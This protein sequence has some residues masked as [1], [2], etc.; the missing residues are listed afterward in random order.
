MKAAKHQLHPF[1]DAGASWVASRRHAYLADEMGLGK[2]PQLAVAADRAGARRALIIAPA[3]MEDDWC[4]TLEDFTPNR[5]PAHRLRDPAKIPPTGD[6]VTSYER[7]TIHR[8]ALMRYSWD[9]VICDE[10]KNLKNQAAERTRA[11]LN[12]IYGGRRSLASVSGAMWLADGT[13]LP[14]NPGELYPAL[15]TAGLFDGRYW[16]F[17]YRFCEVKEVTIAGIRQRKI[18]GPRNVEELKQMLRGY[19]LRRTA[20]EVLPELPPLHVGEINLP[21]AEIDASNPILP[22]LQQLDADAHDAIDASI[23]TGDWTMRH[24]PHIATIRRLTGL[25]KA[26]AAVEVARLELEC[27]RDKIV[28]FGWHSDVLAYL[29][30]Q[31]REFGPVML[32]GAETHAKRRKSIRAFQN[33]PC[34]RVAIGQT[35]AA[36]AGITLTASNRLLVVEAAWTPADNEQVEKRVHRIGQHRETSVDYLTLEKSSDERVTAAVRQKR[37][38]AKQILTGELTC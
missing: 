6:V 5:P 8:D 16:D 31:L 29:Q 15:R 2:T 25:A 17:V 4:D 34:T 14:N 7:A 10:A 12:P 13:P 1:Q 35:R 27:T 24:V 28:L 3:I 11:I 37:H 19:M 33:D 32:T 21:G 38:S 36:G 23:S 20:A 22:I 18:V 30:H 9:V 26:H